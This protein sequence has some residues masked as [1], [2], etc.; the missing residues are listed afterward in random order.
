M[1]SLQTSLY[2]FSQLFPVQLMIVCSITEGIFSALFQGKGKGK[3]KK[4]KNESE[5]KRKTEIKIEEWPHIHKRL[6]CLD[7]FAGCGGMYPRHIS[8]YVVA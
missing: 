1:N 7:V 2:S 6:R 3:G 5:K 8:L 4:T